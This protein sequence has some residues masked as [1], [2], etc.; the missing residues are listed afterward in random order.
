MSMKHAWVCLCDDCSAFSISH[1]TGS[2]GC[3]DDWK[4]EGV[5]RYCPD[6]TAKREAKEERSIE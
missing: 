6:C 3:P 4:A 2:D 5:A 1:V